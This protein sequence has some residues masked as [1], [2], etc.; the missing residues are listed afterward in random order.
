MQRSEYSLGPTHSDIAKEGRWNQGCN[1]LGHLIFAGE[2]SSRGCV[3][4]MKME[5][6]SFIENVLV[7]VCCTKFGDAVKSC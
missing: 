4:N 1:T 2:V 5:V 6:H 3:R 7:G